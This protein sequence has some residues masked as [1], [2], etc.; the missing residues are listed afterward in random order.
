V[1]LVSNALALVVN[2]IDPQIMPVGGGLSNDAKLIAYID[3]ETRRKSLGNLKRELIV[4]GEL[5]T[6]G[7]LLGASF[8]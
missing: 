2:V 4:P 3:V 1:H 7:C 8:L 6:N 5:N